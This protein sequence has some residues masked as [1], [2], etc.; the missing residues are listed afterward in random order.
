MN[1]HL[2]IMAGGI[3]SRFWPMSRPENPKQFIDVLGVGRTLLQLTVDRFGKDFKPEHVWIV[4]S[5][6]YKEKVREQLPDI[7]E[8][9]ILLE[10]CMRNTTPCIGYVAW[11][12]RK[13]YPDATL[14]VSPADHFVVD[15]QEFRRCIST[16]LDFVAGSS[17]I[18]TL[19]MKPTRPDTGYGYIQ[20]G[21]V[22]S[23]EKN[24]LEVNA[25]R[26][27]PDL[28]TAKQ[29]YSDCKYNWNAGIFMWDASTAEAAIRMFEPEMAVLFDKMSESFYTAKEQEVVNELFPQCNKISIDYAVME[30]L[31]G[32][33]QQLNGQ[34]GGVYVMP[35][36]FGWSDLGTWGS[37]YAQTSKDQNENAIIGAE[38]ISMIESTDCIVRASGQ[39]KMVLQGLDGYIVAD[40]NGTLL[41]CKKNQEQRIKEFSETLKK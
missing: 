2:V 32:K 14:V 33:P 8:E 22:A 21:D 29:Y 25:F 18:L 5:A 1:R 13:K 35:S 36:D 38:N 6:A 27:K 11:K 16:G 30:R 10:P 19:G 26:E 9:N 40:D 3:G 12:I 4:T 39:I 24:I 7:P 20:S 23:S 31:A 17:N 34:K 15:T 41:V 37:L 28:Q